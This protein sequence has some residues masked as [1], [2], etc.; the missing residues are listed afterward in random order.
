MVD[1]PVTPGG[2]YGDRAAGRHL[3][4]V[5]VKPE[6][7]LPVRAAKGDSSI[8]GAYRGYQGE[9]GHIDHGRRATQYT[10]ALRDSQVDDRIVGAGQIVGRGIAAAVAHG[11]SK[12]RTR[13]ICNRDRRAPSAVTS[14]YHDGIPGGGGVD[15]G[16]Y[17]GRGAG[18]RVDG[19][20]VGAATE[21]SDV[22]NI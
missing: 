8:V 15:G 1:E 3:D 7:N 2:L 16:L 18:S 12:K 22:N 6:R 17:G 13:A 9:A 20:P 14:G 19:I 5:M 10:Q 21:K 4:V 11:L